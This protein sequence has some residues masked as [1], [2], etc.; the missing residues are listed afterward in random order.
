MENTLVAQAN[1][2]E[3]DKGKIRSLEEQLA[4]K[5][6]VIEEQKY[7]DEEYRYFSVTFLFYIFFFLS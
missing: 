1:E 4:H 3:A 6:S 2:L 7:I 5:D